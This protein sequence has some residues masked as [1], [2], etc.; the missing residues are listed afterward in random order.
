MKKLKLN[1]KL[2]NN[3]RYFSSLNNNLNP[4]YISGFIDAEG[5][6]HVSLIKNSNLKSGLSVR[7]I[8][9]ISLH[10]KDKALLER[11]R[12]F[13]DVGRVAI[14]SD[15]AVFYEVSSI[16]DVQIILKHLETYPLITAQ[17]IKWGDLQLFKQVVDL[18]IN[19][20]HLTSEG[21]AKI[22]NIKASMNF[23]IIPKSII[24]LF[25]IINPVK[26]PIK[27]D[28][29][30]YHPYWVV[31]YTEGEGM[32]FVNLYKRKDTVLGVGVKL[33]FKITQDRRN[34][35]LLENLTNVFTVGKVYKQSPTVKV[36]DFLI[37]GLAD[38][39]KY[40]IPFYRDYPLEGAKK[41]DFN[42]FVLVALT[43]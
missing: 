33:V 26:R 34:L 1:Y 17:A 10:R 12:D 43:S 8:F 16:K 21:L 42:D 37:T 28:M 4:N 41:D 2:L 9:Q 38:I 29:V 36:M 31:G 7:A 3:A 11:I 24:S 19:Q 14:R 25:P 20:E 5:C 35:V 22:V 23:G 6:F 30:I 18:M 15:G 27:S 40:I 13:F 32:F 39:T